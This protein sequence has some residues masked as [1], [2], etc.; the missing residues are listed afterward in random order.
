MNVR[1]VPTKVL[2]SSQAR[3]HTRNRHV[4]MS[5][6]CTAIGKVSHETVIF[7]ISLISKVFPLF[8]C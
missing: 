2:S 5:K 6:R 1:E 4:H 8:S 7:V 3:C